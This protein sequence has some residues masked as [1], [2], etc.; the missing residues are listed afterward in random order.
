MGI[1]NDDMD[2]GIVYL[3]TNPAMPN[4]V[5]IGMTTRNEVHIRM[6]E[7]YSTGVPLPFSCEYAGRVNDVK[8]VER[9]LHQAFQPNRVNPAREFFEIDLEQAMPILKLLS[10]EDCTPQVSDELDKVDTVSKKAGQDFKRKRRPT[11]NFSEMGISPGTE[12]LSNDGQHSCTVVDDR[13]VNYEGQ[14]QSFTSA[15]QKMLGLDYRVA[16]NF[17]WYLDG[18][19]LRDIYNER[20]PH[21]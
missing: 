10:V 14:V 12:L 19:Q 6:A 17:Y 20:Y 13:L 11:F 5:K 21:E 16:P 8:Q 4:L 1:N 7:L 9:A 3:L 2:D 18:K 15:T